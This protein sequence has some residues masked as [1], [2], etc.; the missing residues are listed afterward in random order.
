VLGELAVGGPCAISEPACSAM[1]SASRP[2]GIGEG[3][4][5]PDSAP[6]PAT[7]IPDQFA[8]FEPPA[9]ASTGEFADGAGAR[10]G[11]S[12]SPEGAFGIA[13]GACVGAETDREPVEGVARRSAPLVR[14]GIALATAK[15]VRDCRLR[16]PSKGSAANGLAAASRDTASAGFGVSG[17]PMSLAPEDVANLG[18]VRL[19][20]AASCV[21]AAVVCILPLA[22][23]PCVTGSCGTGPCVSGPCV[24]AACAMGIWVGG[25]CTTEDSESEG[26]P[27]EGSEAPEPSAAAPAGIR[28]E[29][30]APPR[31]ATLALCAGGLAAAPCEVDAGERPEIGELIRHGDA[32]GR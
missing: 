27:G 2:N 28:A 18:S 26:A 6:A 11:G 10:S 17:T 5:E 14:I 7:V 22:P 4:L 8:V 3:V 23:E 25:A 1:K 19:A 15:W 12:R 21:T 32:A 9:R 16:R 31:E 20:A 30:F 24:T 13:D 29:K